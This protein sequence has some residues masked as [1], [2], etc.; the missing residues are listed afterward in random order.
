M[1]FSAINTSLQASC[2]ITLEAYVLF[3]IFAL[4]FTFLIIFYAYLVGKEGQEHV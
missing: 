3:F 1:L 2:C 4:S